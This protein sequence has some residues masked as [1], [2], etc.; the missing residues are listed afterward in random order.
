MKEHT[1]P[2]LYDTNYDR[3]NNDLRT[4]Y[5][6]LVLNS[7]IYHKI[8]YDIVLYAGHFLP[9]NFFPKNHFNK[10]CFQLPQNISWTDK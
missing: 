10:L 5:V 7:A 6:H 4:L 8:L 1:N 3:E 2:L 9:A